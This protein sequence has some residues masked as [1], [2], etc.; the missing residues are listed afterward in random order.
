MW[1]LEAKVLEIRNK[2]VAYESDTLRDC[3]MHLKRPCEPLTSTVYWLLANVVSN[4]VYQPVS[5]VAFGAYNRSYHVEK[6]KTMTEPVNQPQ[7]KDPTENSNAA[8]VVHRLS[9]GKSAEQDRL[10]DLPPEL[11]QHVVDQLDIPKDL[12][13]LALLSKSYYKVLGSTAKAVNERVFTREAAA[14]IYDAVMKEGIPTVTWQETVP[15]I[16]GNEAQ[17]HAATAAHFGRTLGPIVRF[18]DDPRQEDLSAKIVAVSPEVRLEVVAEMS[19]H[20][21]G[22]QSKFREKIYNA[23]IQDFEHG[24]FKADAA[25]RLVDAAWNGDLNDKQRVKVLDVQ[26]ADPDA[27]AAYRDEVYLNYELRFSRAREFRENSKLTQK[28][29]APYATDLV[30]DALAYNADRPER[31]A[32]LGDA[33]RELLVDAKTARS[34]MM[35]TRMQ[36]NRCSEYGR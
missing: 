5:E 32:R 35:M 2:M 8:R 18:L 12:T 11:F 19:G 1:Q 3:L 20:M 21:K 30:K 16:M 29:Q 13:N 25:G 9:S 27:E 22:F 4:E 17:I 31:L 7:P 24:P 28:P 15:E 10:G 14:A 6:A 36:S 33:S 23:V 26:L 34:D